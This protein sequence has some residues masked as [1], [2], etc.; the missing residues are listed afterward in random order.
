MIDYLTFQRQ[1]SMISSGMLKAAYSVLLCM[2]VVSVALQPHAEAA[3]MFSQVVK[4]VLPCMNYMRN[5]GLIPATCCDGLQSSNNAAKTTPHR[6]TACACLVQAG[7]AAGV[8][9]AYVDQLPGKC[10]ISL[11][12][13]IT[14]NFDCSKCG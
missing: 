5:G 10:G 6:R 9:F 7:K 3:M 14:P 13:K 1:A 11:G 8:N 2:A 12:Y 4:T